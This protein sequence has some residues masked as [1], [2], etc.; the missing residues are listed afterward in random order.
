MKRL[1]IVFLCLMVSSAYSGSPDESGIVWNV[2]NLKSIGGHKTRVVGTPK[3]VET[4]KGPDKIGV[5]FNGAGDGLVVESLPLAD[6]NVFTIEVV[7]RP[8]VN[9]PDSQRLIYMQEKDSKNR[10]T[11]AVEART[12][13]KK[14]WYF[15]TYVKCAVDNRNLYKTEKTHKPGQ[16]YTA[17]LVYD[18]QNLQNYINGNQEA[19]EKLI[20]KP[21]KSGETSIGVKLD[22][23]AWFKG[24]IS[25]IRF[26]PRALKPQELLK[27]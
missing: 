12:A 24:V 7:F 16:W 20:F 25:K 17:A 19:S 15:D 9:I 11:M 2:D 1:A 23:T 5:Q 27:P 21:L 18:G 10:I 8:D 22:H 26:T 4:E 13:D 6:V 14:I 3:V